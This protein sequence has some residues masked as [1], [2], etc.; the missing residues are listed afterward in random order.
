MVLSQDWMADKEQS[1]ENFIENCFDAFKECTRQLSR[2]TLSRRLWFF[3]APGKNMRQQR[4]INM[5]WE[6]F[7]VETPPGRHR[8]DN[9]KSDNS[10]IIVNITFSAP[11][12]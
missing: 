9:V 10:Q 11:I 3:L 8:I 2:W 12:A 7:D 6:A 1:R 5:N 4:I